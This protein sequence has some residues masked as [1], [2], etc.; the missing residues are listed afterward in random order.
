MGGSQIWNAPFPPLREGPQT[1]CTAPVG[2][3]LAVCSAELKGRE[4]QLCVRHNFP[5]PKELPAELGALNYIGGGNL[6]VVQVIHYARGAANWIVAVVLPLAHAHGRFPL[7][8]CASQQKAM[9]I[10]EWRA[11]QLGGEGELV[12]YRKGGRQWRLGKV[13]V[14]LVDQFA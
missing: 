9:R 11:R 7:I 1:G 5:L 13:T 12:E 3:A 6:P 4:C 14:L 8:A 10:A 2:D